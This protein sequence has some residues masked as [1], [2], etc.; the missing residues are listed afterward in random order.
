MYEG[1]MHIFERI[2]YRIQE[3]RL[4][5]RC[6]T[7]E[8]FAD[9]V[10]TKLR[11]PEKI[12]WWI[13]Q[14]IFYVKEDIPQWYSIDVALK[15]KEGNCT[16]MACLAKFALGYLPEYKAE[17]ACIYGEDKDRVKKGHAICCF[18]T[19]DLRGSING[20]T[21]KF[22]S[23]IAPWPMIIL[24]TVPTWLATTSYFTNDKGKKIIVDL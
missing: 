9:Y 19:P 6:D 18:S 17:I 7:R 1:T 13:S 11:T 3:W 8:Q 21:V 4:L 20:G 16:E 12:A 24:E 15:A 22:Y 5:R 23:T 10:V 14:T 2:A